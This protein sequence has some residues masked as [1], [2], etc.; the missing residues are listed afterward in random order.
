MTILFCHAGNAH[1]DAERAVKA[2]APGAQF[3]DTSATPLTYGQTIREHW[4]GSDD[5]VIIEQDIEITA[6]VIPSFAECQEPWCIFCYRV[7]KVR[8]VLVDEDENG[9]D[10][11]A[12]QILDSV[13]RRN[14]QLMNAWLTDCL[15]CTKFS[16]ELRRELPYEEIV[17]ASTS[18]DS[19]DEAVA[20][21]LKQAGYSPHVHGEVKHHH[22]SWVLEVRPDTSTDPIRHY[23]W[24]Y[25][26]YPTWKLAWLA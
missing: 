10:S 25:A 2:Y 4:T 20:N 17:A 9:S 22:D 16:A 12:S 26:G 8:E 1:P 3:A 21:G 19:L 18:W 24:R 11:W 13:A 15:G 14:A 6:D 5:L 23:V 7:P